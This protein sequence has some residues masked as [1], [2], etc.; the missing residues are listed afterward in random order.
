MD[1][2]QKIQLFI[3][4]LK[5]LMVQKIKKCINLSWPVCMSHCIFSHYHAHWYQTYLTWYKSLQ[6]G[7]FL[8]GMTAY[9]SYQ[10]ALHVRC[11]SYFLFIGMRVWW[12]KWPRVGLSCGDVVHNPQVQAASVGL[13]CMRCRRDTGMEWL[14]GNHAG[15]AD[16]VYLL[17]WSSLCVLFKHW[18]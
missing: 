13:Y 5:S 7:T 10:T 1:V 6:V 12:R 11:Y 15:Q 3:T 14:K 18:F 9:T 8:V 2:N 17:T 4:N 16:G